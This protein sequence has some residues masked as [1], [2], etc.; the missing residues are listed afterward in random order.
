MNSNLL[1]F[2]LTWLVLST[3]LL[4]CSDQGRTVVA[5]SAECR[6]KNIADI[7][8]A[9]KVGCELER[10]ERCRKI[11]QRKQTSSALQ[12][13]QRIVC[14]YEGM[15]GCCPKKMADFD[16]GDYLFNSDDMLSLLPVGTTAW[17]D[18]PVDA[19]AYRIWIL[20]EG[21]AVAYWIS[22]DCAVINKIEPSKLLG[23]M[24][25]DYTVVAQ[26]QRLMFVQR[27]SRVSTL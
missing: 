18:L 23:Q 6:C 15:T 12:A 2:L 11:A 24:Q 13:L 25:A 22:K 27:N 9:A 17:I 5:E 16:R 10:Q 19:S 14:G 8:A 4:A 1:K 26:K 7:E 20:R 3:V 21:A